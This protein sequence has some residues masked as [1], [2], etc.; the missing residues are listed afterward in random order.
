ML[1]GIIVALLML[2]LL[3]YFGPKPFPGFPRIGNLVHVQLAIEDHIALGRVEN[4][5]CSEKEYKTNGL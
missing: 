3:G 4:G 1:T 5:R 2:W